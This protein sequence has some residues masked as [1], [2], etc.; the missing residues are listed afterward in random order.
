MVLHLE[1][2][3]LTNDLNPQSLIKIQKEQDLRNTIQATLMMIIG[4]SGT[5][6]VKTPAVSLT[7]IS[8]VLGL[9][10]G[11]VTEITKKYRRVNG[12]LEE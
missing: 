11:R 7:T 1:S 10:I 12:V 6:T 8:R 9:S 3:P 4:T 5:G 2:T